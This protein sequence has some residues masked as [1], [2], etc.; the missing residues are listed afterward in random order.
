[1]T[2][3]RLFLALLSALLLPGLMSCQSEVELPDTAITLRVKSD[4]EL[5]RLELRFLN[6]QNDEQVVEFPLR[7]D[8]RNEEFVFL[9][10]RAPS[11]RV[12]SLFG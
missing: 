12:M 11:F 5:N 2:G 3:I 1:M 6:L 4:S 9:F 10:S 7:V 8:L